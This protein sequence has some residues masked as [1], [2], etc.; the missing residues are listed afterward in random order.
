M[1]SDD[2]EIARYMLGCGIHQMDEYQYHRQ[3]RDVDSHGHYYIGEKL[4]TLE[5]NIA[6]HNAP[7]I[8]IMQGV[9]GSGKSSWARLYQDDFICS[10]DHF[11]LNDD[12]V[13]NFDFKHIKDAHNLCKAIFAK[14]I[15]HKVP[16]IV[17]DNTNVVKSHYQYYV[18]VGI[19]NNCNVYLDKM[20]GLLS[21]KELDIFS[22]RNKHGCD[23]SI[24]RRQYENF[25]TEAYG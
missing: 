25:A 5:L 14:Y 2:L 8:I 4:Q 11:Y 15:Y 17:V 7:T 12:G 22:R 18:D 24:I 10:A 16:Q 6:D 13:Y 19:N 9:S 20:H 3:G 21:N 1:T 23:L